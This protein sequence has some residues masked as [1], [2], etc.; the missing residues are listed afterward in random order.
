MLAP[1]SKCVNKNNIQIYLF[2][3]FVNCHPRDTWHQYKFNWYYKEKS[4]SR[5]CRKNADDTCIGEAK[6]I[7]LYV[8]YRKDR[9]LHEW[10]GALKTMAYRNE[11]FPSDQ[12]IIGKAKSAETLVTS[13]QTEQPFETFVGT[14]VETLLV[15]AYIFTKLC[16]EYPNTNIL[17]Y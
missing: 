3:S 9:Y 1:A 6:T 14:F 8:A 10:C 16:L 17:I 4:R 11:C 7:C 2:V 12:R 15:L 13:L 5:C